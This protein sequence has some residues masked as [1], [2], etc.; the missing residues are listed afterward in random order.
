MR[1]RLSLLILAILAVAGLA[2]INWAEFIRPVPLNFG[3]TYAEAPLGLLM[4]GLVA[5]MLLAFLANSTYQEMQA[6]RALNRYA[7]ELEAQRVLA[8]RAEASRFTELRQHLELQAEA[9]RRRELEHA[10]SLEVMLA[11]QRREVLA[12]VEQLQRQLPAQ[13]ATTELLPDG[14]TVVARH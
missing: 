11:G 12:A 5:L 7:Q 3:F 8:D 10:K 13:H 14:R 4:L 1:T 9:Q 6:Q 2:A